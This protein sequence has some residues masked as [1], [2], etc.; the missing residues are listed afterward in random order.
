MFQFILSTKLK[1]IRALPSDDHDI[2]PDANG[3]TLI[4]FYFMRTYSIPLQTEKKYSN[5]VFNIVNI[6]KYN[7]KQYY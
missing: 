4:K 7:Y 1:G 3:I 2:T 6:L 5:F